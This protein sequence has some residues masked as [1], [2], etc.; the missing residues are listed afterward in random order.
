MGSSTS[1][2]SGGGN[3]TYGMGP[4]QSMAMAGNTGLATA[5]TEQAE[6]IKKG[7]G[8]SF[9]AIGQN[10]G[11][12]GSKYRRPADVD[13]YADKVRMMNEGLEKGGKIFVG[14]DGVER[15]SLMGTGVK[16]AQGR[17]VLS[18]LKP[19]LTA[20]A[21]TLRQLGGDIGRGL[22]GYNTLKYKDNT[23]KVEM[24]REK[25]LIP[26]LF[27]AAIKGQFS[28]I[29][30]A[31]SIGNNFFSYGSASKNNQ[32]QDQVTNLPE[33]DIR[34]NER[35]MKIEKRLAALGSSTTDNT[36]PFLTIKRQG[37]GGSMS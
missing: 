12:V 3:K 28:P 4:G 34:E 16:D 33:S 21:P 9:K 25:G 18:I 31:L 6:I 23:N 13:K 27:D 15:V 11:E 8:K 17:T 7:T 20:K 2:S 36:R 26:S 10:I 14:A 29:G 19:E 37:F 1:T 32:T 30:A 24:V 35:K 22:V 5:T